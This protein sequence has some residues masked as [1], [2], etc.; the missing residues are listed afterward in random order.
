MQYQED[1]VYINEKFVYS[2]IASCLMQQDVDLSTS[3]N[4]A[5]CV[6]NY[7]NALLYYLKYRSCTPQILEIVILS[8]QAGG[9]Y[10]SL[11]TQE[12]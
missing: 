7:L 8:F 4:E 3:T 5:L 6:T 11:L 1:L 9:Y 10:N 2:L 12:S